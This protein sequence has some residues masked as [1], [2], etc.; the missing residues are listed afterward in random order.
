MLPLAEVAA[1]GNGLHGICLNRQMTSEKF[2]HCGIKCIVFVAGD[3]MASFA[4]VYCLCIGDLV[5][6][7]GDAFIR[8]NIA[9]LSAHDQNG[10]VLAL[11]KSA[12][13]PIN[14]ITNCLLY[15]SPSPRD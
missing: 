9:Q 5:T 3:H 10:N 15:T 4:H 1:P 6:K 13:R 7:Q 11:P 14:G 2:D 8:N 12:R